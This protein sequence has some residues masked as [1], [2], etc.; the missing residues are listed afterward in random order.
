[1]IVYE[2]TTQGDCEGRSIENLGLYSGDLA[3]I[4]LYLANKARYSLDVTAKDTRPIIHIEK[5]S[6]DFKPTAKEVHFSGVDFVNATKG[7]IKPSH[8]CRCSCL[9]LEAPEDEVRKILD[10]LSEEDIEVLRTYNVLNC[11]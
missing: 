3:S 2:I 11:M 5:D 8:Y 6:P 10:K 1:M 7:R 4:L 9:S